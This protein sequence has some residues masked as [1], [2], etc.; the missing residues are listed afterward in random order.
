MTMIDILRQLHFPKIETIGRDNHIFKPLTTFCGC[1][2]QFVSDLVGNPED[3]FSH[4]E[5]HIFCF[6][7]PDFNVLI[8][9][10]YVL[11]NTV[12]FC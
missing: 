6:N 7:I 11:Q 1:T 10:K 8:V 2:D 12:I 5:A 9:L 4:D 3:R